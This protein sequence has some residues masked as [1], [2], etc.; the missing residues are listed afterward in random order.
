MGITY[1]TCALGRKPDVGKYTVHVHCTLS[2]CTCTYYLIVHVF[3]QCLA[4]MNVVF[5]NL[6]FTST[7]KEI[8][9]LAFQISKLF[10]CYMYI[11]TCTILIPI[12][13]PPKNNY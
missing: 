1:Q 7:N 9:G 8:F 13:A 11:Y 4:Q 3:A 2:T 10:L 5:L 12:I 6:L